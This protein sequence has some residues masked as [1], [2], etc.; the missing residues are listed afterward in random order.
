VEADLAFRGI[1]FRD[2]WLP[3]GGPSRLS[4]RRLFVLLKALPYESELHAAFRAART[5]ASAELLPS[6]RDH[7]ARTKAEQEAQQH[8]S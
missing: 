6:R 8:G 5:K 4:M 1:D 3:R 2:Y 7:Y